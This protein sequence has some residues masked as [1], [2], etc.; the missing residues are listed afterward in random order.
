MLA[1]CSGAIGAQSG[2]SCIPLGA[3]QTAQGSCFLVSV[4]AGEPAMLSVEQ[5]IDLEIRVDG[6]T[7]SD[8]F[9]SGRETA[10]LIISGNYQIEVRA[11]SDHPQP[12]EKHAAKFLMSRSALSLQD[13]AIRRKAEENATIAKR[14]GKAEDISAALD[15]WRKTGDLAAVGRLLLAQ[16]HLALVAANFSEARKADEDALL[17]CRAAR[18]RLCSAEAANNSGL[19]SLRLGDFEPAKSRLT[20]AG[21]EFNQ[22]AERKLDGLALSNLG[23]LL[24]QAGDYQGAISYDDRAR[25]ILQ[26]RDPVANGRVLNNLGLC[27]QSLAEYDV[28]R[29]YLERALSIFIAHQVTREAPRARL[30]LG[31]NYML[32]GNLTAA[33]KMLDQALA[34]A[35]AAEDRATRA[36]ILLNLG[37][38]LYE[39]HS[40]DTAGTMLNQALAL[41]RAIGD[42]RNE[43]RDIQ[44][45][46]LVAA[47][48]GDMASAR[49]YL[50]E[51]FEI[52]RFCALRDHAVDSLSALASLERRAGN[53]E[54]SLKFAERAIGMLE[55]V[56][57]QVPGAALRASF[58]TRRR[59]LFDLL[60]DLEAS[61]GAAQGLLAAEQV[62]ARALMDLLAAGSLLRQVPEDLLERRSS[63]QQKIDLLA[64]R[65]STAPADGVDELRNQ[66]MM[67]VAEDDEIGSRIRETAANQK[68]GYA[69]DSVD[70]LQKGLPPDTTLIEYHL[71]EDRGY[72]W[73]VDRDSLSLF[74]VPKRA[75]LEALCAP[76]L[77]LFP[78]I[79][80][81]K[82][83]P[84][85]QL[86]FERSLRA[87]SLGLLGPLGARTLRSRVIVVPDGVLTR[88][89]F[90]A[91]EVS[92]NRRLG[93]SHQ[94][95]Q[96]PSAAYLVAEGTPKDI[97]DFPRAILAVAD[98]VYSA[99]DPRVTIRPALRSR[100]SE[101]DL[102]RLPFM[103]EIDTIQTLVSQARRQ[104]LRGFDANAAAV[105]KSPLADYA[106]LHFST[107]ALIDDRIPELSRI[108]LSTVDA[109][110]RPLDGFLRPYQL[111]RFS[112][113]GSTVVLS[114]CDTALGKQVVGEG[115]A[116]LTASLFSAGAARLVLTVSEVDAEASA[117]FWSEAYRQMFTA[118]RANVE[119][120]VTLAR[121]RLAAS[122]RWSDPYYWA[123]YAVYGAPSKD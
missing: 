113:R 98:P 46:G 87:V 71:G 110:G 20:E 79:L 22:L 56:R 13:A 89:P 50:S 117:E 49:S 73:L 11:V 78:D 59:K 47:A 37:E 68:L 69:L 29:D 6:Q 3:G 100:D 54:A 32:Q 90:A 82:R 43:A 15:A 76:V 14:T 45:L 31:R 103:K 52:Q 112:L 25:N 81:R 77:E 121:A 105:E 106:I 95:V 27:Y 99:D 35:T 123:S 66:V 91:L 72:V 74:S 19:V 23:L 119:R 94:L 61:R 10:T 83:S 51:A 92:G 96:L 60:V 101:P 55:S 36:D 84:A 4:S 122:A 16:G 42:R 75:S 33:Q 118:S 108:A 102:V 63:V 30:N 114:A 86:R 34:E 80:G 115:L 38:A 44:Y 17:A 107:H 28:A 26:S 9:S 120:A 62:R 2:A 57:S 48:Q 58:Y 64:R 18:D 41:H 116:G 85:K 53:P 12:T 67:L 21:A 93:L 24:W 88:I 65:L 1:L 8:G 39:E 111:S 109:S 7:A 97:S 40:P 5:P 104:I 70:E